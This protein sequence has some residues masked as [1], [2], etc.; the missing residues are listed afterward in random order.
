MYA[1][2]GLGGTLGSNDSNKYLPFNYQ[3]N[4]AIASAEVEMKPGSGPVR[5]PELSLDQKRSNRHGLK[6][7][8]P[9]AWSLW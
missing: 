8:L 1:H 3:K 2:P 9:P 4:L 7:T 6:P 5:D